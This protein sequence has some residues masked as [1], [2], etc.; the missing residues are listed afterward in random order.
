MH[1]YL[2]EAYWG[3]ERGQLMHGTISVVA[4]TEDTARRLA[5]RNR[6][7]PADEQEISLACAP[8]EYYDD[9]Y[10]IEPLG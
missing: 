10:D 2:F 8:P 9:H 7:I 5:L 4:E 1:T 3:S 6:I